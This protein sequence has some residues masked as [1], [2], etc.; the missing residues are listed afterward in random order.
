[1]KVSHMDE[2][3]VKT[4]CLEENEATTDLKDENEAKADRVGKI[5]LVAG[6]KDA[7]EGKAEF[8]AEPK[9]ENEFDV[10]AADAKNAKLKRP[11]RNPV[12]TSR[13]KIIMRGK[14]AIGVLFKGFGIRITTGR[15]FPEGYVDVY[16]VND[17]GQPNFEC[18]IQ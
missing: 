8:K 16:Y 2:N 9:D 14:G 7:N 5:E 13:S 6:L 4:N 18:W 3:E 15:E 17:I 12:R 1:M 11:K 10:R